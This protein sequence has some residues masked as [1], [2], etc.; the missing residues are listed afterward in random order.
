MDTNTAGTPEV[1]D[2]IIVGA[3]PAGIFSA[4]ALVRACPKWR[5]L[6]VERGK[7]IAQRS[8]PARRTHCAACTTCNI[9]TGWGGAGAFSDGKLTLSKDV[10]GWLGGFP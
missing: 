10:G 8:C 9:L 7:P 2:V 3:G 1:Y 4:I 5:I 6:L